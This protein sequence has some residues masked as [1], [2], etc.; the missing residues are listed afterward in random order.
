MGNPRNINWRCL[1]RPFFIALFFLGLAT[2]AFAERRERLIDKWRPLH[3]QVSLAFNPELTEVA[4]AETKITILV[5]KESLGILD[6]D[7]GEMPVDGV[8]VGGAPAAFEQKDGRL[9]VTLTPAPR[10]NE[11]LLVT[12]TYHGKPANGLALTNDKDHQP[13]A[14]GDNWPDRVHHWIP[15]LDH[16]SAKASVTFNVTAPA[17]HLVVAN[18]QLSAQRANP[19]GTRTWTYTESKP[20]PPYCMIVAVGRFAVMTPLLPS[21]VAPL[22]Y[23][24]PP[25][26]RGLARRGFGA[27]PPSLNYLTRLVGPFPYEKLAHIVGATRF[28]GMENSGAIV[29]SST[30]FNPRENEPLYPGFGVRRGLVEVIA[31]ETA[32]Q[33]FGDSVTPATWADLWLSEG[34]ATYFA[35]LFVQQHVSEQAFREFMRRSAETYFKYEQTRRAPIHDRETED[36]FKLL[37]G[38]NYQKGAWVLHMLRAQLGDAAFFRGVR[39]YYAKH[40]HATATTEDLRVAFE[41]ASGKNLRDF[42]QRWVYESGHP[43]YQFS[44]TW[45]MGSAPPRGT[46]ALTLKQTQENEPFLTPVPVD[47]VMPG[48]TQPRRLMLTPTGRETMLKLP[49]ASRPSAVQIDPRN[50]ILKEVSAEPQAE[51]KVAAI[52]HSTG[53]TPLFFAP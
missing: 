23:Y 47:I 16:L 39:A 7:F 29:Y 35:G 40:Q 32:H 36:L 31:H 15:S 9:N 43:Q 53:S 50:T 18:G 22:T 46:L 49:L 24:V 42:F 1:R 27:A 41:R 38:N 25:S 17:Q 3:Y 30:L 11:R 2:V 4:R 37:N 5:L 34:F 48:A 26:E 13:S 28:G 45:E 8:S 10:P 51:K 12:V 33:W 44:W 19:D 20:I 21:K 52:P 14:T 6:L